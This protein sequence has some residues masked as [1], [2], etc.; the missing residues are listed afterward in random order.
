VVPSID[1]EGDVFSGDNDPLEV[2]RDCSSAMITRKNI[3]LLIRYRY[4]SAR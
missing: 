1:E 2:V 4:F 3:P